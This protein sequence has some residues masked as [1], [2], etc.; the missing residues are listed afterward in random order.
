MPGAELGAGA[1][2]TGIPLKRGLTV[3]GE[4]IKQM[5]KVQPSKVNQTTKEENLRWKM[6]Q[7]RKKKK[8]NLHNPAKSRLADSF[9]YNRPM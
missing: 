3:I 4:V 5:D 8:K 9:L 2:K 7:D 1:T 6:K